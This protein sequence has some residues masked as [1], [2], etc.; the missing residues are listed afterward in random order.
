MGLSLSQNYRFTE[1]AAHQRQALQFDPDYLPAKAQLAQDLLRLGEES[2]G[3]ALA[4]EV[5]KQAGYD[6]EMFNLTTLHDTM[7][8]FA[9]LTNSNFVVR[10]GAHEAAVY[11][12]KRWTCWNAP[13]A[14]CALST[15]SRSN[16]PRSWK[17]SRTRRFRGAYV[18]HAGKPWIFRRLFWNAGD[19]QQLG[20]APGP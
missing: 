18:R 10:M 6:V 19:R 14:I 20:S 15:G 1:G 7:A 12:I 5:Q 16:A 17:F 8:K 13:E 3:W 4:D 2:E 9:T 11:G